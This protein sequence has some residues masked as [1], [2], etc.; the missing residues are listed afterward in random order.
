MQ[1]CKLKGFTHFTFGNAAITKRTHYNRRCIKSSQLLRFNIGNTLS[2]TG[3]RNSLHPGRTALVNDL[4]KIISFYI[5]MAVI[6]TTTGKRIV[7][8]GQ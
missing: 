3:C 6:S 1:C 2:H 7:T 5:G 8:L 4:W